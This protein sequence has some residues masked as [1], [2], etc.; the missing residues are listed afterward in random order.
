MLVEIK[1]YNTNITKKWEKRE[2][3]LSLRTFLKI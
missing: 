1:Q 2:K 3:N